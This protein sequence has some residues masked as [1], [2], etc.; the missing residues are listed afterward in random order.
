MIQL[1]AWKIVLVVLA[2]VFGLVFTLPNLL[3]ASVTDVLPAPFAKRLHLGLDLQGG[4][5]LLLE[6]DQ[7]SLRA[8]Q[9][10]N[11]AEDARRALGDGNIAFSGLGVANGQV[12]ARINNP[13]QVNAAVDLLRSKLSQPRAPA[14]RSRSAIRRR[15]GV[16]SPPRPCSSPSRW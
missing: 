13:G 6:V 8:E 5:Y 12:Q 3:P 2:A 10:A 16:S 15:P 11:I 14:R 7:A 1:R 9:L 4:S